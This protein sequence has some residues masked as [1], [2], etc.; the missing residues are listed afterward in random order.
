MNNKMDRKGVVIQTCNTTEWVNEW[1]PYKR[2]HFKRRTLCVVLHKICNNGA[3]YFVQANDG[4]I[5]SVN[6][7]C[8]AN[9]HLFPIQ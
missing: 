8:N 9:Y 5:K 4:M 3:H 2:E 1:M 7:S 6:L